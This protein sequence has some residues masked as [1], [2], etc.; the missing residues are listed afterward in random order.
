MAGCTV[1]PQVAS[2]GHVEYGHVEYGHVEYGSPGVGL[3]R[4]SSEVE[5]VRGPP[6][7][8]GT[9]VGSRCTERVGEGRR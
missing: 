1:L 5:S 8:G 4:D 2:Y 6:S 3:V 7:L 9:R